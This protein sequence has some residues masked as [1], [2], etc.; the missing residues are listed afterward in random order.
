MTSPSR[1]ARRMFP[2]TVTLVPRTAFSAWLKLSALR[3]PRIGER[4]DA[5]QVSFFRQSQWGIH[6]S[7]T[8][9]VKNWNVGVGVKGL[10]HSLAE[11][12]A[13]G[14]GMDI[15]ATTS[16]WKGNTVGLVVTDVTTSWLVWENGSIER[17][18][19]ELLAGISQKVGFAKIPLSF[20]LMADAALDPF[21]R[22]LDDDFQLGEMGGRYRGGLEIQYK[23]FALRFGRGLN[24]LTSAGLGLDWGH[25]AIHYAFTTVVNSTFLGD[26]HLLSFRLDPKWL[27]K[28]MGKIL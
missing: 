15:G 21:N 4:L 14:I 10:F 12:Y 24:A 7:T 19:P 2:E 9:Q 16:F 23:T 17:F 20:T 13:T 11:H 6:L 3:M 25:M 8:W 27:A 1:W 26:S 22:G 5:D 18:S 28:Q